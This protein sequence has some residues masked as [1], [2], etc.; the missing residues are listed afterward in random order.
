M[1][2]KSN[3]AKLFD[4]TGQRALISGGGTG[5]GRQIALAFAAYG[6]EVILAARRREKLEA[7]VAELAASGAKASCVSMDITDAESV[8][9]GLKEATKD[10]SI[11]LLVNSA[12]VSSKTFLLD[13]PEDEWD[14]V[15]GTNLKGA[16]MLCQ[17]VAKQMIEAEVGGS[18]I[19]ISSI[20]GIGSQKG[21]GPYMASK[22]GL[23]HLTR[24]MAQEWA[25]YGIRANTVAPGYFMTDISEPYL[26]TKTGQAMLKKIPLRRLGNLPD[27]SGTM[28]L[29]ASEAG[30]YM[31]GGVIVVDGG[32]SMTQL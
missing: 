32:H 27:L 11:T 1:D 17:A 28:L 18:I 19:N 5:I 30:A 8:S 31:T 24:N 20:L 4:L 3:L 7:T 14:Q 21:A 2:D 9:N 6:A 10:G 15:L 29:L 22:A 16:W 25:R 26:K 13:T 12:G 23:L